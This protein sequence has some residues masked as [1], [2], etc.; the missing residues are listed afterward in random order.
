MLLSGLCRVTATASPVGG[1]TRRPWC[2]WCASPSA[3]SMASLTRRESELFVHLSFDV[4]T[5]DVCTRRPWCAFSLDNRPSRPPRTPTPRPS[6]KFYFGSSHASLTQ[7]WRN[8]PFLVLIVNS[9][10]RDILLASAPLHFLRTASTWSLA[11]LTGSKSDS[12]P[13]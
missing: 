9:D 12:T 6:T 10:Q 13:Y 1:P 2:P 8:L 3:W 7:E 5:S 4:I 11:V